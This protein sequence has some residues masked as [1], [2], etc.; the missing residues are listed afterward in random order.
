M[1]RREEPRRVAGASSEKGGSDCRTGP[2]A[3]SCDTCGKEWALP[4]EENP[5]C[6][7]VLNA[8]PPRESP[9]DI[10]FERFLKDDAGTSKYYKREKEAKT[11]VHWGQRKLLVS[12]IEFLT[13]FAKR[14]D[15]VVYVGSASGI[16]IPFLSSLFHGIHFDLYD[17]GE[18]AIKPTRFIRIFNQLFTDDDALKYKGRDDILFI[19]DIRS[20]TPEDGEERNDRA[21]RA[22][23]KAQMEWHGI[24]VPRHSMFKFRLPWDDGKTTYLK[25]KIAFPVRG[26]PTTTEGRLITG[27][28]ETGTA[29]YDNRWYEQ[30]MFYFNTVTRTA[31]Y[32]IPISDQNVDAFDQCYDCYAEFFIARNYLRR[33][34][35]TDPTIG[36]IADLLRKFDIGCSRPQFSGRRS[37]LLSYGN[38]QSRKR[39]PGGRSRHRV[40]TS[41][42]VR[43]AALATR[44]KSSQTEFIRSEQTPRPSMF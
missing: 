43:E 13:L 34:T 6:R 26:P 27:E 14:G 3:R 41:K 38:P 7:Q 20:G 40:D 30:A 21:I 5:H 9:C 25:G 37:R 33:K 15:T 2:A 31:R 44:G 36:E 35:G 42:Q 32:K 24:I 12:E 18:F 19:S 10:P 39:P 28:Y 29:T 8:I 11:V 1:P 17:P 4:V 16:H 23:M 22:D